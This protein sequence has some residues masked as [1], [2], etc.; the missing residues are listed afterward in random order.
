MVKSVDLIIF[1]G[2]SNMS[3]RGEASEAPECVTGYEYKP[4]SEPERLVPIREPFGLGEDKTGG[5]DDRYEGGTKRSGSMVSA[6]V[7]EYYRVC[8]RQIVAV[9]ASKG[10]TNTIEW[11]DGLIN[12]AVDRLDRAK[13]FLTENGIAIDNI[14]VIWCQGES[15]G[16]IKQ[17]EEGYIKSTRRLFDMFKAHG[18]QKCFMV[19]IG[20]YNYIK[21]PDTANRDKYYKTIRIAQRKL[22]ETDDDFILA[23]SLEPH[24][25]EMKDG[26][27]YHQSAY[28]A[29]GKAAGCKAGEYILN[30]DREDA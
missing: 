9:S 15:D 8:A 11:L 1:A 30:M 3:G 4:I 24:I 16:D 19:Q 22:C 21:Y 7:N 23:A 17:T 28:N 2:Q 26:Y 6:F 18:A 10:G 14:F 20:H 25:N 13:E 29:V 12:D 27:H 5:L